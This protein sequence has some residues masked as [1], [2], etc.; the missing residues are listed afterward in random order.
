MSA[1]GGRRGRRENQLLGGMGGVP[2]KAAGS[3]FAAHRVSVSILPMLADD[4]AFLRRIVLFTDS[5]Q[6][7]VLN[8]ID[9][10]QN[11]YAAL[12]EVRVDSLHLLWMLQQ[13]LNSK[14]TITEQLQV[15][16]GLIDPPLTHL[17]IQS[18]GGLAISVLS[19]CDVIHDYINAR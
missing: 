4:Q 17:N 7:V 8:H 14:S 13:G 11:Q 3:Q 9:T 12:S 19:L 2:A 15:H 5:S 18:R 1:H 6:L 10:I 16:M